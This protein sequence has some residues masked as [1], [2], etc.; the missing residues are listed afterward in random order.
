MRLVRPVNVTAAAALSSLVATLTLAGPLAGSALAAPKPR[1]ATPSLSSDQSGTTRSATATFT[2]SSTT[3][4]AKYTC[5]LDGASAGCTSPKSY[6]GLGERTHSFSVTASAKG[7]RPSLAATRSWTVDRTNP[8]AVVFTGVPT[9]PVKTSPSVTFTG[10]S[11]ATFTCSIDGS[12]AQPCTQTTT[13]TSAVAGDGRH[14]LTVVVTDAAGNV[15]PA[16]TAVWTL[17]TVAP[18]T[19]VSNPPAATNNADSEV[20][21]F[22]VSGADAVTHAVQCQLKRGSTTV[23]PLADCPAGSS[24]D[25]YTFTATPTTTDGTYAATIVAT[26]AAGNQSST[27]VTWSRMATAPAVPVLSGPATFT[28]ASSPEIS[29]ADVA[30]ATGYTC[31]VDTTIAAA[32]VGCVS[33]YPA[34]GV[35]AEGLHTVYVKSHDALNTSAASAW[36]WT[37][38]ATAPAVTVTGGPTS[39][40]NATAA[41]FAV[42]ASDANNVA[43]LVCTVTVDGVQVSQAACPGDGTFPTIAEGSYVL[44]VVAT[45]V[46]GNVSAAQNRSWTVDHTAP[47][48]VASGTSSLAGPLKLTFGETVRELVEGAVV[49]SLTDTGAT[50]PSTATCRNAAGSSVGCGTPFVSVQVKPTRLLTP[51]QHYTLKVTDGAVSDLAGNL[52]AAQPTVFRGARRGE[53]NSAAVVHAW[54]KSTASAAYGRSYVRE[55][56]AGAQASYRFSGRS[57]TWTTVTG[58]TYG[59]AL[60]L[61]DGHRKGLVNN[62]AAATHYKVARTFRRLSARAHVITIRVLGL[63][64]ARAGRGTNV[65]V[66]AFKVGTRR[67]VTPAVTA[68]WKRVANAKLFGAH[69]AVADLRGAT[70]SVAFRGT[71]VTWYTSTSRT[72]GKVRVYVDGVLKATVDNYS[73]RARF[74]VARALTGLTDKVHT[75]RL[76]VMGSHRAGGKGTMIT[77]DR[78]AIA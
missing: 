46:A 27:Q 56:L 50:V 77:V 19:S 48:A 47:A 58:P 24:A 4:G 7:F 25:T 59:K 65:A 43:S 67:T 22:S 1:A 26:D 53:E 55:H 13:G 71:G 40:S 72:Q 11:G 17:D 76:V 8:A 29:W 64:G 36:S 61:I 69:A 70:F 6:S 12:P 10:E 33:P 18:V 44:G 38:D 73:A 74:H 57:I 78:F 62:Y 66:D 16:A 54:A 42:D 39:R 30:G 60:V 9:A 28:S 15:G 21:N 41:T 75:L 34:A 51:G 23:M 32:F 31:A 14:A 37:R 35:T 63:K 2:F 5:V 20:I 68:A 49:L 52:S 45:D 3:A